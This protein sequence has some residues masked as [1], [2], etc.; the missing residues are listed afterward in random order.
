MT[1]PRERGRPKKPPGTALTYRVAPSFT[2][3]EGRE[4]RAAADR[5]VLEVATWARQVLLREAR[6]PRPEE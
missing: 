2:E 6:D 4:I 1:K 3:S 5:E